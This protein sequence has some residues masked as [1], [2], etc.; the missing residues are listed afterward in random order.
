MFNPARG[1]HAP[2]Y[3]RVAFYDLIENTDIVNE[4]S[5]RFDRLL[6]Q[7]W[8]CPDTL[9]SAVRSRL[10]DFGIEAGSVSQAVRAL[11]RLRKAA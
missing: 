2:E 6:G 5:F 1:G 3:L 10:S 4:T 11:K 9:P 7:L 8:N